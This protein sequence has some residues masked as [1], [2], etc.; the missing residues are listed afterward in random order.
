MNTILAKHKE[1]QLETG[2]EESEMLSGS[3]T[4]PCPVSYDGKPLPL[5][6]KPFSILLFC[7]ELGLAIDSAY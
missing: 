2:I 1:K 5:S 3:T 6:G 4:L 7:E